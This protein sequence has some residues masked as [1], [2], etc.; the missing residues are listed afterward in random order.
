VKIAQYFLE[1][2]RAESYT[3]R[4]HCVVTVAA[5]ADIMICDVA[6]CTVPMQHFILIIVII[7][8]VFFVESTLHCCVCSGL[9]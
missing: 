6:V 1:L 2:H 5:T 4:S 3:V 9:C 7:I 8:F